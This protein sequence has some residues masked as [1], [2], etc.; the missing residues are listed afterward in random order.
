[1]HQEIIIEK[2]ETSNDYPTQTENEEPLNEFA[3]DQSELCISS[4][5]LK[6]LSEV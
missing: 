2:N 5:S 6:D 1:V 3:F 4:D